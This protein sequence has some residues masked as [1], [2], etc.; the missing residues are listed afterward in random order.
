MSCTREKGSCSL[1]IHSFVWRIFLR[2]H[3]KSLSRS[4]G[5][6]ILLFV[7]NSRVNLDTVDTWSCSQDEHGSN[8]EYLMDKIIVLLSDMLAERDLITCSRQWNEELCR[9]IIILWL[10]DFFQTHQNRIS[11]GHFQTDTLHPSVCTYTLL[12][13]AFN[14]KWQLWPWNEYLSHKTWISSLH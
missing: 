13:N 14:F 3:H 7:K 5:P 11:R 9:K 2:F 1:E 6:H 8:I 4:C 10:S 12:N